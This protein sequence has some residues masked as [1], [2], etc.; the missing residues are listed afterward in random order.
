M[1]S[2]R[3]QSNFTETKL[4]PLIDSKSVIENLV[5]EKIDY[6]VVAIRNTLGGEVS[7][8]LDALNSLNSRNLKVEFVSETKLQIHHCLFKFKGTD[9]N[10]INIIASHIQ[11]L[12]QTKNNRLKL[13]PNME[14]KLVEDTGLAAK[15]LATGVYKRNIAVLCRKNAGEMYNLDLVYENLE[16]DSNN[17]TTFLLLKIKEN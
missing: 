10:D 8:T 7:E 15:Y 12:K 6:G 1:Q 11:A 4:V 13:F 9:I 17:Y 2:L 14:E 3:N 5:S 16:D